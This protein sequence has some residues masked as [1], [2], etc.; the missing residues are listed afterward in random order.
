MALGDKVVII[1]GASAGIGEAIA[2]LLAT[3]KARLVLAAR[4]L[5]KLNHLASELESLGAQCLAVQT[6]VSQQGDLETLVEQ[7]IERFGQIV[8][9]GYPIGKL[10]CLCLRIFDFQFGENVEDLI[11]DN[12]SPINFLQTIDDGNR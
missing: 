10:F 3:Q 6:D 7:T 12:R 4:S 1:T 11:V 8:F 5:D 2:R 9:F